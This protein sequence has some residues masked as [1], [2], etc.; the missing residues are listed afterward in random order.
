MDSK[1]NGK[2]EC[3]KQEM[4]SCMCTKAFSDFIWCMKTVTT[5]KDWT[6]HLADL[7]FIFDMTCDGIG[8]S[9][10]FKLYP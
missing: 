7:K 6:S 9:F 5:T 3:R 4:V 10:D 2:N 8:S 1:E